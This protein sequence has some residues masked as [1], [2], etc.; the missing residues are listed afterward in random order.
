[1]PKY[2]KHAIT[3]YAKQLKCRREKL[4]QKALKHLAQQQI[5]DLGLNSSAVLDADAE[6]VAS[7]LRDKGV[8]FFPETYGVSGQASYRFISLSPIFEH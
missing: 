6:F 5:L 3:E 8:I 2:C 1:M 4:K 7:L